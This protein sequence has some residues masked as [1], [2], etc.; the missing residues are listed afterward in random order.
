MHPL[1]QA[2]LDAIRNVANA[3]TRTDAEDIRLAEYFRDN[4]RDAWVAAGCPDAG[5]VPPLSAT[6][7]NCDTC[8]NDI[9]PTGR[10]TMRTCRVV[11]TL[12]PADT[13]L[14]ATERWIDEF[15]NSDGVCDP[16]PGAANCPGWKAR[17]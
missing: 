17:A 3:N 14:L 11:E 8:A 12:D 15:T 10:C 6:V 5:G 2:M 9:A 4:A 16:K 13:L 7:T 1:T